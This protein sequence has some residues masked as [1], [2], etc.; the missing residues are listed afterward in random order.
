MTGPR[1]KVLSTNVGQSDPVVAERANV[2]R[3]ELPN[4]IE[5]PARE[6]RSLCRIGRPFSIMRKFE[7]RQ[8]QKPAERREIADIFEFLGMV[9]NR[10]GARVEKLDRRP[11]MTDHF[12]KPSRPACEIF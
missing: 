10:A 12:E 1:H 9:G 4:Q 3:V 7:I 2:L 8:S 6:N 11:E 5:R